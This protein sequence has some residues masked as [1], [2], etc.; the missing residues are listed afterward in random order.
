MNNMKRSGFGNFLLAILITIIICGVILISSIV[1]AKASGKEQEFLEALGIDNFVSQEEE[2]DPAP[3]FFHVNPTKIDDK[4]LQGSPL[5]GIGSDSSGFTIEALPQEETSTITSPKIKKQE[6]STK[7]TT[8]SSS[9]SEKKTS[10][11]TKRKERNE[12]IQLQPASSSGLIGQSGLMPGTSI[13]VM[14]EKVGEKLYYDSCTVA[15]SLPGKKGFPFAVTAGHCGKVGDKV[16]ASPNGEGMPQYLGTIRISS[17]SSYDKTTNKKAGDWSLISLDVKATHPPYPTMVPLA[18]NIGSIQEGTRLC[19]Y[20]S[21]SKYNCGR[22]TATGVSAS[23]KSTDPNK[24][25]ENLTALQDAVSLCAL[26]GDSGGPIFAKNGIV[27]VLSATKITG[28][29]NVSSCDNVPKED[30]E[31]FYVP[32]EEVLKEIKAVTKYVDIKGI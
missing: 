27:G 9:S 3:S 5:D 21:T 22:K 23:I 1:I 6:K 11:E 10:R 17:I 25:D 13:A 26:P 24:P 29:M 8:S 18:I 12:I 30:I 19:K 20:G 28:D 7:N 32:V 14:R 31:A 4:T 16:Y 15:F 2:Y